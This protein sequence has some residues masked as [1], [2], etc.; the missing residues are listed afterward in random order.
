MCPPDLAEET[1][2][3]T[4]WAV[5]GDLP[6]LCWG[7]GDRSHHCGIAWHGSNF[8]VFGCHRDCQLLLQCLG[9]SIKN[10]QRMPLVVGVFEPADDGLSCSNKICQLSLRQPRLGSHGVDKSCNLSVDPLGLDRRFPFGIILHVSVAKDLRGLGCRLLV[11]GSLLI[12]MSVRSCSNFALHDTAKSISRSG[13]TS[14][15]VK[16]LEI[17][18]VPSLKK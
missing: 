6:R 4:G 2:A 18:A 10:G 9:D 8:R 15:F 7:R 3:R 16:P 1:Q 5:V 14:S 17:T 13:T 11:I 12:R